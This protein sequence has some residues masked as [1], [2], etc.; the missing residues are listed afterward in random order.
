MKKQ[1][2]KLVAAALTV[3]IATAM[4]V[5]ISY[6]WLTISESP[7]LTG[8]QVSVGGGMT[9]LLAPD[10][11]QTLEDGTIVH[12]PGTF[13]NRLNFNQEESYA[14]L[15]QLSGLSPVSTVDGT[16]W[17]LP[18]YYEPSDEA[19]RL[20]LA[21]VGDQKPISQFLIDTAQ[22]HA[23]L[24]LDDE[25]AKQGHY[26][27]LD[28]WVV[29]PT[30]DYDLRLTQGE[31]DGGSFL[32]ELPRVVQDGQG[33]YTLQTSDQLA[34]ASAR[35]GFLINSEPTGESSLIAYM[36]SGDYSDSFKTLRGNFESQA[37][38]NRFVIYEP[39]GTLHPQSSTDGAYLTTWPLGQVDGQICQ[40]TIPTSCLTVQTKNSMALDSS[41]VYAITVA[42]QS[43]L[44]E[45]NFKN[46]EQAEHI[47]YRDYLQGQ[48]AQ[49][50]E[51]GQFVKNM[52]SF[53]TL[54]DEGNGI[55]SANHLT[56][57]IL[58]TATDDVILTR[59][60]RNV[61]QRIRM[62]IWIE[63]QDTDCRNSAAGAL[64]ALNLELAGSNS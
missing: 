56:E 63:G 36:N 11:T 7:V 27:Y 21:E 37:A 33:G 35:I 13:S 20:G 6:A 22:D 39:N 58:S 55:V 43:A 51:R 1:Y 60:E 18:T 54:L 40:L 8:L 23:N 42:F 30:D 49:Y 17:V 15:Q 29:S 9:I 64:L 59:L 31:A 61:P 4:V 50:V 19:V 53:E 16:T 41:G 62:Y 25:K 38:E 44:Y 32:V 5:T 28:F 45:K 24:I 2:A 34:A 26:V 47:L 12:Y 52:D 48:L 14:Y 3:I 57:D 10:I 46:L